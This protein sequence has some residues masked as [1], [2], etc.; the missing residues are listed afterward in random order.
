MAE[1]DPQLP[2]KPVSEPTRPSLAPPWVALL[3]A[4]LGLIVLIASIV[5]VFLPIGS[6]PLEELEH[7][8]AYSFIERFLPFPI[9]GI[10]LVLC[11]GWYGVLRQMRGEPRPLPQPLVN[12]RMQAYTGIVL[13]LIGAIVIY[14]WVGIRGPR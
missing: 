13:A 14:T 3:T 1:I 9:Y 11:L 5:F 6:H 7:Q 12:Q 10:A 8:R 2:L 4:W